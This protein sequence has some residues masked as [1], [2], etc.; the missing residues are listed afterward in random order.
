[1]FSPLAPLLALGATC[2]CAAIYTVGG[3][4]ACQYGSVQDAIDALPASGVHELRIAGNAIDAAD[5]LDVDGDF[6]LQRSV[7]WQPGKTSLSHSGGSAS[8]EN[9][10][11]SERGSLDGGSTPY[12]L[13][14]DPRFVDPERGDY[15]LRAASPAIDFASTGGGPDLEGLP[16]ALDLPIHPDRMGT[17]DLG[18]YERQAVQPLVLNSGFDADVHLWR[19]VFAGVASWDSGQNAAGGANSGSA[20]VAQT[21]AAY[22]QAIPGLVQCI[23][24]PG[25]GVYALDAWGRGTG[26]LVTPGDT[27]QLAW[28]YRRSGGENCTDGAADAS[29]THLLSNGN[30]WRRPAQP[31]LIEVTAEEWTHTSSIAVTLVAVESGASAEPRTTNAWFDGVTLEILGEDTIFANGFDT[32]P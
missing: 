7:L 23:H 15:H 26:T 19:P 17:A 10:V 12:V 6:R 32:S 11:T 22:G 18:A 2:A 14:A 4:V 8:A 29:G 30:S 27:A 21:G 5:V 20:Q 1:M 3:D 24:L 28:D 9:V 31:A 13:E 25:P 16:R